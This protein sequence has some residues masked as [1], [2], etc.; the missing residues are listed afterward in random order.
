[1]MERHSYMLPRFSLVPV[2]SWRGNSSQQ[3]SPHDDLVGHAYHTEPY[4]DW[5]VKKYGPGSREAPQT[6]KEDIGALSNP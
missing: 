5:T 2:H 4:H 3:K 6:R 1:M